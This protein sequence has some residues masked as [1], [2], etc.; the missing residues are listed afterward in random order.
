VGCKTHTMVSLP[1][2]WGDT[3]VVAP[4]YDT[5]YFLTPR[6]PLLAP[7]NFRGPLVAG[8]KNGEGVTTVFA[9]FFFREDPTVLVRCPQE[10]FLWENKPPPNPPRESSNTGRTPEPVCVGGTHK[11][12]PL[13]FRLACPPFRKV[14]LDNPEYLGLGNSDP[15]EKRHKSFQAQ[16]ENSCKSL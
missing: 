14:L 6:T 8:P 11:G 3:P 12:K 5:R 15:Q 16:V 9:P 10:G 1:P 13:P 7:P 2:A 4:P